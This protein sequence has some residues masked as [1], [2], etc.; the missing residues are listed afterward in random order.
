MYAFAQS[1]YV[2]PPKKQSSDKKKKEKREN[3][4]KYCGGS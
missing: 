3:V 4:T 2:I 1:R